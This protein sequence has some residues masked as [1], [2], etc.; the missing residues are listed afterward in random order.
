M[1]HLALL[2]DAAPDDFHAERGIDDE[3]V[4]PHVTDA[5][6]HA[7]LAVSLAHYRLL[8][9]HDRLGPALRPR[10][11]GKDNAHHKGLDEA[12]HDALQRH[13]YDGAGALVGRL[14][15]TVADGVLGLQGK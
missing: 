4:V 2:G 11:L 5:E 13:G 10:E 7:Q 14:P 3:A 1:V 6:D 9:E 8:T 12:A 15:A